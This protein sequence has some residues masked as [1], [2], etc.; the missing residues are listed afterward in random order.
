MGC[1]WLDGALHGSCKVL[2]S[3][4][5]VLPRH[6][7]RT[8]FSL[9]AKSGQLSLLL[10]LQVCLLFGTSPSRRM[11]AAYIKRR[12]ADA[13]RVVTT[14]S[15]RPY[16]ST[17]PPAQAVRLGGDGPP[18]SKAALPTSSSS[19][20][21][22][23]PEEAQQPQVMGMIG[24]RT[25]ENAWTDRDEAFFQAGMILPDGR[26]ESS[27]RSRLEAPFAVESL[28][29]VV[30]PSVSCKPQSEKALRADVDTDACRLCAL[31][32]ISHEA[33]EAA[34]IGNDSSAVPA[35]T[36][37]PTAPA[38]ETPV[39][40]TKSTG[41]VQPTSEDSPGGFGVLHVAPPS[42]CPGPLTESS[43][44]VD[45][46]MSHVVS[47]VSIKAKRKGCTPTE[48]GT[49][50]ADLDDP[51]GNLRVPEYTYTQLLQ[52]SFRTCY[53]GREGGKFTASEL[54]A[55]IAVRFPSASV[56]LSRPDR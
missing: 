11:F 37:T 5:P 18:A 30:I 7:L 39:E 2:A 21:S 42:P 19:N 47:Q 27:V 36:P 44:A 49:T 10:P 32:K 40:T 33:N 29:T 55:A 45:A 35:A 53:S 17:T 52:A 1:H 26:M 28:G 8:G 25:D 41:E 31:T 16:L 4:A 3:R 46:S 22:A 51:P 54:V 48:K 14:S 24:P 12:R 56:M 20:K 23:K 43:P 6:P 50:L 9:K 38:P 13:R 15:P 34:G